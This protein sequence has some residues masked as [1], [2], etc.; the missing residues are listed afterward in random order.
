MKIGFDVSPLQSGHNTRGIGSYTRNTL[1]ELKKTDAEIVEITDKETS[2]VDVIFHPYFDF[3]FRTLKI[4]KTPTVVTIHDTMPLIF[5]KAYPPGIKGKIN[6][7]FQKRELKKA[8]YIITNSETS[9]KDINKY[10]GIKMEKIVPIYLAAGKEF[11]TLPASQ[12]KKLKEKYKLPEKFLLYVGDANYVKNLPF[13]IKGFKSIKESDGFDDL[14]LVLVGGVF[15]I[16][17]TNHPELRSLQETHELIRMNKLEND[18]IMPGQVETSD[19]V[20]FYNLATLYIQPSL[21]EGFGIPLLEA[22]SCGCPVLSSSS[23]SLPEVG[24]EAVNYFNPS[25]LNEFTEK[26][27]TIL[28]NKKLR[29]NLINKGRQRVKRFSW[30]KTAEETLNVFE[31]TLEGK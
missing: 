12:A 13:L 28:T 20:S 17:D 7:L 29:E 16:K 5:T 22:M 21:Y 31:K 15:L 30:Q 24:G 19:L 2:K 6:F 8:K 26:T 18:V 1:E 11:K 10:L 25:D 14:K 23:A 27:K 9:K 4:G 3:F